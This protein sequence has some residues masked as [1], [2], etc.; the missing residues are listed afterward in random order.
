MI[1]NFKK[2]P[3]FKF[4]SHIP[5][6]KEQYPIIPAKDYRPL[7]IKSVLETYKNKTSKLSN[8]LLNKMF[9]STNKMT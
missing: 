9:P 3:T 8:N 2:T 6:V 4:Y 5:G 7:W 1:F